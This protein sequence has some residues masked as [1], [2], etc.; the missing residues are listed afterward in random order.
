MTWL[1]RICPF[2]NVLP[3][4]KQRDARDKKGTQRRM[5]HSRL[6]TELLEDRK[7]M[8]SDLHYFVTTEHTDLAAA[9]SG[10]WSLGI[11]EDIQGNLP[12]DET[13]VY[14]GTNAVLNR[15][16]DSQ[17]G[18]VGVGAN[19]PFYVGSQTQQ[20]GF[21]YFGA[22]AA[23]VA[24]SLLNQTNVLSESKNRI[25]GNSKW[26]KYSLLDVDHFNPNGTPGTGSFSMWSNGSFGDPLVLMSSYNDGV[27]NPN[28][29]GLDVTDGVSA[30]DALWL[31][32]G[33]HVHYNL[34]FTQPG[35]YEVHLQ[36]S[37]NFVSGGVIASDPMDPF[38]LYFSVGSVGQLE[39]DQA[40]YSVSESAGTAS[41]R[42]ERVGGSDGELTVN[43]AT[44]GL[45]AT[46]GSDFTASSG[47]LT[48]ADKETEKWIT[49]PILDDGDAEADETI[50]ISLSLPGPEIMEIHYDE[51]E[52]RSLLGA[53]SSAEL[54]I[55]DDDT[56]TNSPPTVS[57]VADQT[58]LEDTPVTGVAYT[59]GDAETPANALLVSATSSNTLL[60]PNAAITFSGT[61][62]NR[63]LAISPA[64]N[65]SGT[66]TITLTVT[67]A[68]GATATDTFEL[69]VQPVNDS[70]SLSAISDQSILENSSTAPIPFTV[71]DVES[72]SSL[73]VVSAT[74]SNPGLIPNE[75]LILAGSG[76][77]R[78][79]QLTP[80]A[81]QFGTATIT[82]SVTDPGGASS[83]INFILTVEAV[84]I[85]PTANDDQIEL[86]VGTVYGNVLRNDTDEDSLELNVTLA[87]AP[88][89]GTA[90]LASDGQFSYTPGPGFDGSDTF[91][92]QVHDGQGGQATGVVTIVLMSDPLFIAG[93]VNGHADIGIAFEAGE[94]EP[95]VHVHMEEE[96]GGEEHEHGGLEYAPSEILIQVQSE[97]AMLVPNDP[98]YS[99]LGAVPGSTIYVLP[100]APNP[101]LP[102]LG[103]GTEEIASETFDD[104]IDFD[105]ISVSGPGHFS[106]WDIDTLGQPVVHM[107]TSDG[108][109]ASDTLQLLEASH[110]HRQI[111]FSVPGDY[112]LTF[113]ASAA[114]DGAPIVSEDVTYY[115]SVADGR[116]PVITLAAT[117]QTYVEQGVAK[118]IDSAA[119]L[120]DAD[121]INF[122]GGFLRVD[123]PIGGQP[124]DQLTIRN[125]G[126]GSG[127][128]SLN[129]TEIRLG[130]TTGPIVLGTFEGGLNGEPLVISLQAN[131]TPV[132]IQTLMRNIMFRNPS[133]NPTDEHRVVRF[134]VA[135][136]DGAI[137]NATI[138]EVM[139]TP[140][141]DAPVVTTS[142]GD[143]TYTEN[144]MGVLVDE[145]LTISDDDSFDFDLGR[146]TVSI[147]T[148]R[149]T[150]DRLLILSQGNGAGEIAVSENSVLYEGIVIGTVVGGITTSAP[151]VVTLNANA[152]PAAVQQLARRVTFVNTGENPTSDVRVIRFQVNDGDGKSSLLASKSV[153]VAVSNDASAINNLGNTVTYTQ[154]RPPV[155]VA[156]AA[157]VTDPDTTQFEGGT[158]TVSLVA[159]VTTADVLGIRSQGIG[160]GRINVS[161]NTVT[162]GVGGIAV[163]IGTWSGGDGMNPLLVQF[164]AS[165]SLA[166]VQAVVRNITFSVIGNTPTSSRTVRFS[167][168]DG[169]GGLSPDA[170]KLIQVNGF[171]A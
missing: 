111:G 160:N 88:T 138:R 52:S 125:L 152:T 163:V 145:G 167:L 72:D 4:R 151:L 142:L 34:G 153:Q 108:V 38:I 1:Q 2:L 68:N 51:F 164:N 156:G 126:T 115:F 89:K 44:A 10:G 5:R 137:S 90:T 122:D 82:V 136:G 21:L 107:A 47:V 64:G 169:D 124:D 109:N 170:E 58:T 29:N 96:E 41:I 79:I 40:S 45:S 132:R 63:S 140:V 81:D 55:L 112:A 19:A 35:R 162:Y 15:P 103:F 54:T 36:T 139:V 26:V 134:V 8:A 87:T 31:P 53:Q 69:V 28:G 71:A 116:A 85:P 130:S 16:T 22:D 117:E 118:A 11:D 46:A 66:T 121:S 73:L 98:N 74:S 129:G 39:L 33:G 148:N 146:L 120:A 65:A 97:G 114:I 23:G 37:A 27:A 149:K 101:D 86:W 75:N 144:A 93:L 113:R 56:A 32:A 13:L 106:I 105:L 3:R 76:S 67:D 17:W 165:A 127:Q 123:I 143:S 80:T 166:A 157:L 14:V 60:V 161:G 84:N 94:L 119:R 24:P 133:N 61:G 57:N 131:A 92:Y 154:N 30:D 6:R 78:T 141:N 91:Q 20:S 128:I 59:V 49:I 25:T 83:S 102:F 159:G 7:L 104:G 12:L 18:F 155:L 42:V 110:T 9:Y 171:V 48:F 150:A 135:D 70:P 77:N 43:Y 100:T 95:H 62:S 147:A 50:S 168:T 158:L 99:F